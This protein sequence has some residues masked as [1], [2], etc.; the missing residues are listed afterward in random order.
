MVVRHINRRYAVAVIGAKESLDDLNSL[1]SSCS[2]EDIERWTEEGLQAQRDRNGNPMAMD[3][4][5]TN[6]TLR[7]YKY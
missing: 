3:I 6:V 4:Y 1:K 2:P 5:D 7:T